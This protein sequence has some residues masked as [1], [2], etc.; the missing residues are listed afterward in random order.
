[1]FRVCNAFV[2][3]H[4]SP[5]VT[6]W[7]RGNLLALLYVMFYCVFCYFPCGVLGQVWLLITSIPDLCLLT[8]FKANVVFFVICFLS[9]VSFLAQS[10]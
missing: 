1:M 2:S 10:L 5:V 3:V 4:C 9:F 8:Y 7:E 6:C